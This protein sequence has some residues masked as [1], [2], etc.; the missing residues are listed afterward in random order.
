MVVRYEHQPEIKN[1]GLILIKLNNKIP[2]NQFTNES[3]ALIATI[4]TAVP[5]KGRMYCSKYWCQMSGFSSTIG[6]GLM[7]SV[8]VS[9]AVCVVVTNVTIVVDEGRL[10]PAMDLPILREGRCF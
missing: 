3:F 6:K 1:E 9:V 4:A 5:A 10:W 8:V 7:T 2:T